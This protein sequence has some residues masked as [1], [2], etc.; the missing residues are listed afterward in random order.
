MIPNVVKNFLLQNKE[1]Q[2]YFCLQLTNDLLIEQ[3]YGRPQQL[4]LSPPRKGLKVIDI[5]PGFLPEMYGEEFEIPFY[6]LSE[7]SVCNIYF[8]NKNEDNFL[9]FVDKSEIFQVTQKYQQFAHED[10]ISKNKFKR[11]AEELELAKQSLKKSNQ[12]KATLI[13]MLSHELGTP[14]TSIL[15]YCELLL[16]EDK[17]NHSLKVIHRNSIYLQHLIENTL[18]FGKTEVDSMSTHIEAINVTDFLGS[19][20]DTILPAAQ[21]KDIFISAQSSE[22]CTINIDVTRTKQILINLLNNA[23]KYS[24]QGSV[25]ISC[26]ITKNEYEFLISDKGIGIDSAQQS[27]IFNPWERVNKNDGKGSGIGLFISQKLANAIGGRLQLKESVRNVGSVF[28]LILPVKEVAMS[29][30]KNNLSLTTCLHGKTLLVIDDDQ[31]V[32]DLIEAFLEKTELNIIT[33]LSFL[34]AQA[35]LLKTNIDL[36]LTDLNVGTAVAPTFLKELRNNKNK[37]PVVLMSAMPSNKSKEQFIK[38]GFNKVMLKPF[39]YNKLL[40][41]ITTNI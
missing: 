19:L 39:N 33:A 3:I 35:I 24:D 5:L 7:N 10:N 4:G 16:E 32:L 18:L 34:D 26:I 28:Q 30:E 14:L 23:V 29:Q 11:I 31:D 25:K 36:V 20:V 17:N 37:V 15:G 13:A 41:I 9:I 40:K 2:G 27:N 1:K 21:E 38:N 8:I 6:N 22:E 12:E